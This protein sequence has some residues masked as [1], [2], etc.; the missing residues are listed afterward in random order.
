VAALGETYGQDMGSWRWGAAHKA[1]LSSQL[2][3]R[4]PV[5]G[6]LFD[7]GLAAPGGVETVNRAGFARTDGVV[8]PDQHGPGY[9]SVFDLADLDNSRFIIATGESG[10]PL[11]PYF[12]NL[13]KRWRDGEPIK[14][15]GTADEVAARG[16]GRMRFTP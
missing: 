2:F 8:F 7:V 15:T 3:G 14:L 9:R 12:G 16:L 4:I 11:S 10:N 6:S 5:L 1:A 13:T